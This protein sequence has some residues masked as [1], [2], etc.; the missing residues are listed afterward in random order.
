[1]EKI[2]IALDLETAGFDPISDEVLE[3]AAIKFQG[4]KILETFET[5]LR[6][7]IEIPAM[8]THITGITAE[9]VQEAPS[10]ENI[11]ENLTLFL[12]NFPIVGHN[13]EF[14][15]TF[16]EAKGIPILSPQLDTLKLS[17]ILLPNLPSYSLDT[18]SRLLK[19][20]HENKHRAYSDALVCV[21]LFR[22]L[23]K[24]IAD[25]PAPLL[26]KIQELIPRTTWDLGE[27]FLQFKGSAPST[28][29]TAVRDPAPERPKPIFRE[30]D[31]ILELLGQESPLSQILDNYEYRPGQQVFFKKILDAAANNYHLIAE[32]GTGTGKT[33]AYLL[34]AAGLQQQ[35]HKKIIISTYTNNLQDQIINKDF[36][37]IEKLFPDITI[38][39][40]KGRKKYLDRERLDKL[41]SKP[42]LEEH[43][44]TSLIKI[45]F[46]LEE[47]TTGDLDE[48]N[49]QNK[50][51]LIYEQI[52]SDPND[53]LRHPN[54]Q[55]SFLE[56]AREKAEN[57]DIVVVNHALLVQDSLSGNSL[58]P[59][60]NVLI[61]D[62]AH[63]LE[64]TITDAKTISFSETRIYR[65][66]D[67]LF[68][69]IVKNNQL[70]RLA[71][72][73][74]Q[75][76]E[77]ELK[78]HRLNALN[79]AQKLFQA[80]GLIMEKFAGQYP[81]Q[82][83]RLGINQQI[84][85]NNQWNKVTEYTRELTQ[86]LP[87]INR[88][89]KELTNF[90]LEQDLNDNQKNNVIRD[91][92]DFFLQLQDLTQNPANKI[93]WLS[94]NYDDSLHLSYAPLAVDGVFQEQ[95]IGHFNTIV[96]TSA[97]LSTYGN[98]SYLRH[99][100][101]L[102]EDFEEIKIP[103]H[104]SYPDQVKIIIPED[105][106]DPRTPNYLPECRDIIEDVIQKNGGRTL[107][108]FT[109][110]K[111]LSRVFHD[112][113]PNLKNVGISLLAQNISGGR[114]KIL[115]HFQDEPEHCAILGTNSFW[116][117][118]DL[119]GP[120]LTCVVIQK[121]P[122][123]PPDDPIIKARS[124]KFDKPFEEYT[125]PRAILR[126]KQGFGRLIRSADDTGAVVILDSR[127]VQKN[128]GRE[129]IASL[130]EGIKI[131]QCLRQNTASHL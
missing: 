35:S 82:S 36:P 9:T 1:M 63:H 59:E 54:R 105:L 67:N 17:S 107:V 38:T 15:L 117:G 24:K 58:L 130:P 93:V 100:L 90:L 68:E 103:S 74:W 7:G 70:E 102:G 106:S 92:Q 64:K 37:L 109:A 21:E 25:I 55:P 118:V 4:N 47:T 91:L 131:H 34:A 69:E 119:I 12:G 111:E 80:V 79:L 6:P 129:F 46:W 3:I 8:V 26:S 114:G 94:R 52:C 29:N 51:I 77:E 113:A 44:L 56:K 5:L 115:S 14:D 120:A 30:N 84:A 88:I 65:L 45:L 66:W 19:L 99:E 57:S 18:I 71:P 89:C 20:T 72:D 108:L 128:Y 126:F 121:L 39:V 11:R 53:Q 98:F 73:K 104:F 61:L 50:E 96:L 10:F 123:D 49:L 31:E 95:I 81:G 85:E 60:A 110:K 97:T 16:L 2:Y 48:L 116:E 62:E 83:V 86:S 122:F 78:K 101:G 42:N 112:L 75:K 32:A 33:M 28:K 125:L 43:E 40:L 127:L 41:L 27:I 22:V 87:D 23:L 76:L 13:I 124:A